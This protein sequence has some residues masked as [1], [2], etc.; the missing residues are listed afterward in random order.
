[1]TDIIERVYGTDFPTWESETAAIRKGIER[2]RAARSIRVP[3]EGTHEWREW[4]GLNDPE[5][6]PIHPEPTPTNTLPSGFPD[7]D[8]LIPHIRM[9][10]WKK[11]R[12][13][14]RPD[15][16][17]VEPHEYLVKEEHP[18]L[19]RLLR[20]RIVQ[21]GDGYWATYLGYTNWYMHLDGYKYW[22]TF[23]GVLNRE[24]LSE[25]T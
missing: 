15:R 10:P 25:Q 23:V 5:D 16:K 22:A 20:T 8:L 17:F 6:L 18:D 12:G 14:Y 24:K 13:Y 7:D 11:S 4:F 9:A 19:F 2:Y 3:D 1:M 21:G